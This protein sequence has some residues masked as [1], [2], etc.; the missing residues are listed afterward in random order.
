MIRVTQRGSAVAYPVSTIKTLLRHRLSL[1]QPPHTILVTDASTTGQVRKALRDMRANPGTVLIEAE[2]LGRYAAALS[3]ASVFIVPSTLDYSGPELA[4][5]ALQALASG[6]PVIPHPETT[7]LPRQANEFV[8]AETAVDPRS[9]GRIARQRAVVSLDLNSQDPGVWDKPS[10]HSQSRAA[11]TDRP[12]RI[13]VASHDLKFAEAAIESLRVSGHE[14]RVD[15]WSGHARHDVETSKQLLAWADTVWCEWALGNVAWYSKR[16]RTDQRLVA[17]LHLQE[18]ATEF[19][20]LTNWAAVDQ[21]IFVAEHVRRQVI[22]DSALTD[23]QSR[24]IPNF[25]EPAEAAVERDPESRFVLGLVGMVPAR[26]GLHEALNVLSWLRQR[27]D[28]YRLSLRGKLP[29]EYAWADARTEESRYF[30]EQFARIDEEPLLKDAV[31]LSP[32]G[33]DMAQWYSD[34][35][36]ALSTSDFE[37]F[38]YTIPDGAIAGALPRMLN[39]PGADLLYPSSWMQPTSVRLAEDIMRV[40]SDV[41]L[42]NHERNQA[43]EFISKTYGADLVIPAL[44]GEILGDR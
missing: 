42:W 33:P 32:F 29:E 9:A 18:A 21:C 23:A 4:P 34:V 44:V 38:H 13:L 37:S 8:T 16:V 2:S 6:V 31:E 30:E 41:E 14:V 28:R 20:T 39:W 25:V 3:F 12:R 40:T 24:V 11:V 27:D 5:D 17:R 43:R 35:G 22:R 36:V 1:R 10:D 7:P 15:Q 19:P 26:K